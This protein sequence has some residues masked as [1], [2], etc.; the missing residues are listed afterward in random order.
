MNES[1][2]LLEKSFCTHIWAL[3]DDL[4][5]W[6]WVEIFLLIFWSMQMHLWSRLRDLSI[7]YVLSTQ[8]IGFCILLWEWVHGSSPLIA[9]SLIDQFIHAWVLCLFFINHINSKFITCFDGPLLIAC[10]IYWVH[11]DLGQVGAGTMNPLTYL[12]VLGPEPWNVA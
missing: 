8:S 1:L 7:I 6:F 10:L 11:D 5:V 3:R 2:W 4:N 12:R 9:W